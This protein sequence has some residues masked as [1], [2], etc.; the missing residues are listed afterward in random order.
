MRAGAAALVLGLGSHQAL[1]VT[2]SP[3]PDPE[4]AAG[5]AAP[6]AAQSKGV[7][8]L[9]GTQYGLP[10]SEA[11]I[12]AAVAALREKG[13]SVNDLFVENLDLVRY[14]KPHWR[15]AVAGLL[16]DKLAKVRL[17]LVI[18]VN[19]GALEFLA[20]EGRELVPPGTPI[21]TTFSQLPAVSWHGAPLP[22]INIATRSDI[23]RTLHYGLDLFPRTR[24]V[25]LVAS[26]DDRQ[27]PLYEPA[28]K[29]LGA[30]PAR[31]EIEDSQALTYEEMLQR[32]ATLPPDTLV[33]L[34]AYF[35]DWTGRTFIPAE[36][37]AQVSRRTNAPVLGL[38][39]AHVELGL[40]G[41]SVVRT[42][43]AGQRAGEIGV[44][45]LAGARRIDPADAEA[46]M[47]PQPMFD[48]AQLQRWGA[49]PGKLPEDTLYL[50]RPSS[51]WYDY[52]ETV[53]AA[54]AA[55]L[56]LSAL[57]V[58]LL[59]QNHRRKRVEEALREYQQG[60]EAMVDKRTVELI[61]ARDLAEQ[62]AR[63]KADFLANMS[64]EI[65]TPMNAII[66]MA[67]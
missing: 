45:L 24:R 50:N 56:V 30:L 34:G 6:Q 43:A 9:S 13:F 35:N 18:A 41:G 21:L 19:Q 23:E 38:Y 32:V 47:P 4:A 49:D 8:I 10:V 54:A 46:T 15:A 67:T 55:F 36:V 17:G 53:I 29:V 11:V 64:H 57:T 63:A 26:A 48:W 16:R 2:A 62:A 59:L 33:L 12:S 65:R 52:R 44:E 40:M 31:L 61:Q 58:A 60:L 42:A 27:F 7:L 28:G 51:L 20:Q 66:G 5:L 22:I 25:F 39:E 3:P 1:A 14:D 37:V